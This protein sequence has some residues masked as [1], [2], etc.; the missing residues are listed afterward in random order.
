MLTDDDHFAAWRERELPQLAAEGLTYADYTGSAL[1]PASLLRADTTRMLA[2]TLGNPHSDHPASRRS[3][4]DLDAA[5]TALLTFLNAPGDEYCVVLTA[6]ASA[7]LRLVGEAFPFGPDRELLLSADNHNSVQGIR[8][9]AGRRGAV[10]RY[11]PLTPELR[12]SP[13]TWGRGGLLAFPAQSNFSGVRHDLEWVAAARSAGYRILLDA[14]AFMPTADLDLTRVPADFVALSLYKLTGWPAGLGALVARRDALA[15]LDR[16]WFAGGTVDWVS[17][18]HRRHR[19]AA[20]PERFEDGTP[21]FLLAGAIAPAL[22]LLV[23]AG[24]ARLARQC[25]ALTDRLLDG[26]DA[27]RHPGGGPM[28]RLHGPGTTTD[29]GAT[30]ALSLLRTGGM[31]L[32]HWEVEREAGRRSLAVRGG[33]FC[34][35]GCAEAAFDWPIDGVA[36]VLAKLGAGF[37]IPGFAKAL[38]GKPVG[39]VRLS[40]GLG[41]VAADV[42]RA[43]EVLGEI[44]TRG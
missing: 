13:P 6:N 26:L 44:A 39:A 17:V 40:F 25:R 9:F 12:L 35:P 4:E 21:A 36:G 20:A 42:D 18:A 33:C 30:V 34:N 38:G 41:S 22:G 19:L 24:R 15:E 23:E 8:E 28:V 7:A 32:P 2:R 1:P 11:L 14:A 16:P 29:R 5:R 3:G 10:V 31:P 43:I 37:T 27:L